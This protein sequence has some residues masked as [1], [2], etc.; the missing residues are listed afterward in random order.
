MG[1]LQNKKKSPQGKDKMISWFK[2]F[3]GSNGPVP[4][5]ADIAA[6]QAAIKVKSPPLAQ[7]I[8]TVPELNIEE[9]K[10]P[11]VEATPAP[12]QSI[13]AGKGLIAAGI[14]AAAAGGIAYYKPDLAS[15]LAN[16]TPVVVEAPKVETPITPEPVVVKEDPKPV[17]KIELPPLPP[18]PQTVAGETI[19]NECTAPI[20]QKKTV[21]VIYV[22]VPETDDK[23]VTRYVYI[24]KPV[25]VYKYVPTPKPIDPVSTPVVVAP[26]PPV[27]P[28]PEPTK[29]AVIADK[30]VLIGFRGLNNIFDQAAFEDFAK[31]QGYSKTLVI[32]EWEQKSAVNSAVDSLKDFKTPYGLYGFSLGGDS[33]KLMVKTVKAMQAKGKS[34]T[35]PNAVYIIGSSQVIPFKD[36]FVGV[37]EVMFWFHANTKHDV[38][39]VFIKA[40]HTGAGNIQQL[41]ADSIKKG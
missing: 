25:V 2:G 18:V 38:D 33:A 39:G 16:P 41:V 28:A 26:T 31:T 17:P 35:L 4:F 21:R 29:P 5:A 15:Q 19:D 27:A 34:A 22:R 8:P 32:D 37:P 23:G 9:I 1:Q 30:G 3:L 40:P 36:A 6:Q 14:I 12:T 10:N 24:K 13:S 11:P 7:T 20:A